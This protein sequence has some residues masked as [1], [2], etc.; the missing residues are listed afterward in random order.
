MVWKIWK[1][2]VILRTSPFTGYLLLPCHFIFSIVSYNLIIFYKLA[3][4]LVIC[5]FP[6]ILFSWRAPSIITQPF[7]RVF[8]DMFV[9]RYGKYGRNVSWIVKRYGKYGRNVSWIVIR[10][11]SFHNST[12]VSSIFSISYHYSTHVSSIFSI[13]FHYSTYFSSIFL[14]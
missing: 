5:P 10:T 13:C 8:S 4:S 2:L 7:F 12:D 9:K 14:K 1:K 3:L 6:A 11:K